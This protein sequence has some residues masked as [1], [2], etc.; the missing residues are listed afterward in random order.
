MESLTSPAPRVDLDD[1]R[2]DLLPTLNTLRSSV[3][4]GVPVPAAV[5]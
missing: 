1:L 4:R 5:T 2:V 3:P